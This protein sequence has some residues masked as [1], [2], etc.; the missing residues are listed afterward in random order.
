MLQVHIF[1]LTVY[2]SNH[3]ARSGKTHTTVLLRLKMEIWTVMYQLGQ[4]CFRLVNSKLEY[5]DLIFIM[6]SRFLTHYRNTEVRTFSLSFCPL[7]WRF[8]TF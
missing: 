3:L 4:V 8:H 1:G 6:V 7:L 5:S 2:T